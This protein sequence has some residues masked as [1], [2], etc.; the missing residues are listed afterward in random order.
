MASTNCWRYSRTSWKLK[1]PPIYSGQLLFSWYGIEISSERSHLVLK[2]LFL[3]IFATTTVCKECSYYKACTWYC[4]IFCH[5]LFFSRRCNSSRCRTTTS[6][7]MSNVERMWDGWS[8]D[9]C[10]YFSDVVSFTSWNCDTIFRLRLAGSLCYSY[11]W[12]DG[13]IR[14]RLGVMLSSI[15]RS[16]R[17]KL[18]SNDC[19]LKKRYFWPK[20]FPI[21][22]ILLH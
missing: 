21:L 3:V 5:F 20:K 12:T 9:H 19:K 4:R 18:A 15:T 16:T 8:E 22:G 6:R 13:G 14:A 10:R 1:G 17:W 11:G 2:N 7:R